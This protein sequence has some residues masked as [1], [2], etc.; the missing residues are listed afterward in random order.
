MFIYTGVGGAIP[1]AVRELLQRLWEQPK[2]REWATS[3]GIQRKLRIAG[4]FIGVLRRRKRLGRVS[5]KN[6]NN[7][8]LP[9]RG[10]SIPEQ[11]AGER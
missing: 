2:G 10:R 1:Q 9:Q 8:N 6:N 4:F 5:S 11:A 7:C 3:G